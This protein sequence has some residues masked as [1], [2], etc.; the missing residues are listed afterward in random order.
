MRILLWSLIGLTGLAGLAISTPASAETWNPFSRSANSVLMAD[1]DSIV[2]SG[3][4]TS[5]HMATAA[6]DGEPGDYSHSIETYEFQ[7]AARGKWRTTGVIEYGPD[8]AELDRYPEEGME[9]ES[10]RAG[11]IPEYLKQIACDGS[12][13]T[14]PLWPSIKAFVDAG[15]P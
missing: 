13:S 4:I 10:P 15:R 11:T 8:G 3:D 12:R 2:V 6:L 9:W 1:T 5:L 14:P 7:C